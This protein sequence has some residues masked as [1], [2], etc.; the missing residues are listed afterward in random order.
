MISLSYSNSHTYTSRQNCWGHTTSLE[1]NPSPLEPLHSAP[2][3]QKCRQPLGPHLTSTHRAQLPNYLQA[4]QQYRLGISKGC[5]GCFQLSD[6]IYSV[7]FSALTDTIKIYWLKEHPIY[8]PWLQIPLADTLRTLLTPTIVNLQQQTEL[9]IAT[10]CPPTTIQ[11]KQDLPLCI[12][13]PSCIADWSQH[14]FPRQGDSARHIK[15]Q[16][17]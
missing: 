17:H 9:Q 10:E 12:P 1:Q 4:L 3:W 11:P 15:W 8:L 16:Q 7:C 13:A 6:I 14:L 5:T 2:T